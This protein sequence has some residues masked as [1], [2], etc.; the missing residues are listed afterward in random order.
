MRKTQVSIS[1]AL[2]SL[3]FLGMFFTLLNGYL[4]NLTT[5]YRANAWLV[6]VG[7]LLALAIVLWIARSR[8]V[9]A[10]DPLELAGF[11][12]VVVGTWLY[13]VAPALPTLLPPTQSADAVRVYQQVMFSYPEGKLV[14]WYPAGGAFLAAMFSHWLGWAPLRVLHPTAAG[15]VALSAGAVYGL[16]CALLPRRRLSKIAALIAPALLF[17]PWSYFAGSIDWEQ[18]FFAQVLAQLFVLAA[19]WYTASYAAQPNWIF[20]ALIGAA[21]LST[22]AAYPIF[23]ALP[24]AL[25]ALVVLVQVARTRNRGALV[26]LGVFVALMALA[27]L[28]LQSGGILELAAGK[29]STTS[30]VGPGGV[31]NPSLETLGGPLFLLLALIGLAL[32]WKRNV[33]GKE[34][35][36][37]SHADLSPL[38]APSLLGK[39][40]GVRSVSAQ[41]VVGKVLIG[42]LFVWLLQTGA[43]VLIQP[44]LQISGYRI[45][46]TF[47]FLIFPLAILAALPLYRVAERATARV[48]LTGR[49]AAAGLVGAALLLSAGVL[50]LRPPLA[51]SPFTESELQTAFWAKE[52]LDTYQVSYL[53]P[54]LIRAY[55]LVYGLWDETV[56]NEWF[57]WIPAGTR[58]G[59]PTFDEWLRDPA[60]PRWVLLRDLGAAPIAPARVVYQNGSSAIV[61]KEAPP[62]SAPAP[63]YRARW[64]FESWIGMIGY[65][66]PRATFSPGETITLTTYTQS[67]Y[68]PYFTV[69]WRVELTDHAGKIV[70]MATGDPFG[71]KY[72]LQRWPPNVLARDVWMLPIAPDAAPGLYDL[73]MGLYRRTDGGETSTWYADPV[74]G[75]I[76]LNKKP[77]WG[78]A[79]FAAI[80]IPLAPP[81]AD[82]LRA[83]TPLDARV[84]DRFSLSRYALQSDPATRAVHLALY[85]Q[86]VAKTESDYTV[87]V[88]LLDGGGK[89]VAQRDAPPLDGAYPTSVWDPPEIVKDSYD[90]TIPADARGPF[91]VEIG[92]YEQPGLKRLPVG[93]GDH[94]RLDLGF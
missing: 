24:L 87:F 54:Q 69:G 28:A 10:R 68:P 9:V 32:A 49:S 34:G 86:S 81:S 14:S 11:L 55:W 91:S 4:Q 53:D 20:A 21:L 52:H 51:Y 71:N 23:V 92:M 42:S 80:K 30:D 64:Y 29:I 44:Y 63:Q 27:A 66:L 25:F 15:F 2:F 3:L 57:Q 19:L 46:K 38:R 78:A 72:P 16:T 60:W 31:T 13:F 47:Y 17:A 90:L 36:M 35:L 26:A 65:D 82:E 59:P 79:P 73:K 74:N 33:V 5:G 12:L 43:L 50:A 41:N 45:D 75:S 58:M 85:W 7:D 37:Q 89:V 67:I 61:E 83:A 40:V 76:V 88:H 70:S 6:L 56:P 39:G 84:G 62:L 22:V 18:Y 77:V 8:V 93:S 94:I 1:Q 48:A